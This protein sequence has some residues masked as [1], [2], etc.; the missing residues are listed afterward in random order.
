M[1]IA[2]GLMINDIIKK[3]SW[4]PFAVVLLVFV[5]MHLAWNF[6]NSALWQSIGEGFAKAF[7]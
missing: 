5:L 3:R 4:S 2:S 1:A 6:R 7:F